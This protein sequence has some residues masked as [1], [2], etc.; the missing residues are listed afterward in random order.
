VCKHASDIDGDTLIVTDL[1]IPHASVDRITDTS[2]G[3]VSYLVTPEPDYNGSVNISY[4]VSDGQ[5]SNVETTAR[6]TINP[7]N[8]AITVTNLDLNVNEDKLI[9]A[10]VV[11]SPSLTPKDNATSPKKFSVGVKV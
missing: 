5:G 2:T 10:L 11:T 8:D 7:V 3:D 9:W 6:L 4:K 1:T